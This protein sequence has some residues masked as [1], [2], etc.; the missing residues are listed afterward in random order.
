MSIVAMKRKSRKFNRPIS[1]GPNGFSLHG[2]HSTS[3]MSTSGLMASR[4]K[5]I[6]IHVSKYNESGSAPFDSQ[7]TYIYDLAKT[8]ETR[9]DG[10]KM[11][12]AGS[13]GS[14]SDQKCVAGKVQTLTKSAHAHGAIS[15]GQHIRTLGPHGTCD[16]E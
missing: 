16:C 12:N 9:N 14:C 13:V 7:S 8:A 1:G 2:A 4:V 10:N 15:S 6:P 5:R 11:L 3:T